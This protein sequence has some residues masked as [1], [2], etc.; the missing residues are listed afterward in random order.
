MSRWNSE[1]NWAEEDEWASTPVLH[2]TNFAGEHYHNARSHR[3]RRSSD[4]QPERIHCV[5]P[6]GRGE[7]RGG[8]CVLREHGNV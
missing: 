5:E 2:I 7:F 6:G 3:G 8:V 1:P 4:G